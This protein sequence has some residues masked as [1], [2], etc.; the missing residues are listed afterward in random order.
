M[1]GLVRVSFKKWEGVGLLVLIGSNMAEAHPVVIDRIRA[2]QK[3]PAG[4]EGRGDRPRGGRPT[5]AIADL[6]LP[7][8]PGGDIALL[9]V[10]GRMLLLMGG[11]EAYAFLSA[12]KFWDELIGLTHGRPCDLAGAAG[13][14]CAAPTPA[15]APGYRP[16]WCS[17]PFTEAICTAN[18]TPRII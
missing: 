9:N 2:S 11:R 10:L 16:G 5:A 3:G 12:A 1:A 15:M 4:T 17:C 13:A 6:H 18:A 8:A 14:P 7:V